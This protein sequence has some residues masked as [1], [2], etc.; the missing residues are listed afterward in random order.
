MCIVEP[1]QEPRKS[2]TQR[3]INQILARVDTVVGGKNTIPANVEINHI[4]IDASKHLSLALILEV[5]RC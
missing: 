2:P 1:T 5:R 4:I 3:S